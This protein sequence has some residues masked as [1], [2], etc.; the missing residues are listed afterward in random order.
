MLINRS[1]WSGSQMSRAS[2]VCLPVGFVSWRILE[3]FHRLG[4]RGPS[5]PRPRGRSGPRARGGLARRLPRRAAGA[6]GVE[7]W[8]VDV[9]ESNPAVRLYERAGFR[10]N[11]RKMFGR[12]DP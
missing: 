3:P 7:F 12:V 6:G 2:R 10:P 1:N 5:A 9:V 8:S 4:L 11:Y